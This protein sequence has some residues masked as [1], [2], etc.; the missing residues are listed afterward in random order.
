M[1]KSQ[2]SSPNQTQEI[3]PEHLEEDG[4][5][6]DEDVMEE[7]E[8]NHSEDNLYGRGYSEAPDTTYG[9]DLFI[10]QLALLF[11][12]V[13]WSNADIIGLSMGGGIAAAYASIFPKLVSGKVIFVASADLMAGV[14]KEMS[15]AAVNRNPDLTSYPVGPEDIL[16]RMRAL[17]RQS[18][19]G[20]VHALK[21]SFRDGPI[22]DMDS[23]F[24][25]LSLRLHTSNAWS[26]T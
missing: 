22:R 15:D 11:Q 23:A 13:E 8:E 4:E 17:Q 14:P 20:F 2:G 5:E 16:P 26:Y 12:N 18:L 7:E 25:M 10:T 6:A 1:Q 24:E 19:P 21:S 9:V 3:Q